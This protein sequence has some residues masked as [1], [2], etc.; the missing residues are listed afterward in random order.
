[1]GVRCNKEKIRRLKTKRNLM[2]EFDDWSIRDLGEH[3][4]VKQWG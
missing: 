2:I 1:M 4:L 3:I